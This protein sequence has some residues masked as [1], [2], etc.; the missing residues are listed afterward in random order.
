[1]AAHEEAKVLVLY[2]GGTI[3]MLNTEKGYVPEKG[4]LSV[5]HSA[6]RIDRRNLIPM[7]DTRNLELAA[8]FE[9]PDSVS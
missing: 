5:S 4:Y 9:V 6:A 7:L 8:L 3:G 2:A 1:M